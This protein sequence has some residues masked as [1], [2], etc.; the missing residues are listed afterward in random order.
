MRQMC[1]DYGQRLAGL[2]RGGGRI[3]RVCGTCVL[4]LIFGRAVGL[5]NMEDVPIDHRFI[6]DRP[7]PA[8]P[9]GRTVEAVVKLAALAP[10]NL[11][12]FLGNALYPAFGAPGGSLGSVPRACRRNCFSPAIIRAMRTP[13]SGVA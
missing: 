2:L 5:V 7:P 1:F 13:T 8:A 10:A 4:R 11:G 6:V 3:P 9:S 12:H